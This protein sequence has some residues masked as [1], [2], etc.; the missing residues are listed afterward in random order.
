M[1]GETGVRMGW[2]LA[3]LRDAALGGA[4]DRAFMTEAAIINGKSGASL[5]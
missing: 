2:S 4:L 3:K 5:T 1:I